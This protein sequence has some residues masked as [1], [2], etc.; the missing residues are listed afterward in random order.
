MAVGELSVRHTGVVDTVVDRPACGPQGLDLPVP[1]SVRQ[2]DEIDRVMALAERASGLR[3]ALYLGDLGENP[4]SR[5]DQL[6]TDLGA[7]SRSA[8]L[9]AISPRQRAIEVVTG[10]EAE[11]RISTRGAQLA[12]T[13]VAAACVNDD[14]IGGILNAFRILSDQAGSA[15]VATNW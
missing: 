15:P 14:L 6:L 3:M 12:V 2:R 4:A 13:A 8:V 9:L 1:F 7:P 5:A 11:R 10:I